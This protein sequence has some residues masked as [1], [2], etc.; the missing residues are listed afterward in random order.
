MDLYQQPSDPESATPTPVYED[1]EHDWRRPR[2]TAHPGSPSIRS[3]P[4][5]AV[6]ATTIV[7]SIVAAV[8]TIAAPYHRYRPPDRWL[9]DHRPPVLSDVAP[10]ATIGGRPPGTDAAID[11]RVGPATAPDPDGL[12]LA[13]LVSSGA[14]GR[15]VDKG[16]TVTITVF[17]DR[18]T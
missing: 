1:S 9:A 3:Q 2:L 14:H 16:R 11:P 13:A 7:S 6:A 18:K 17:T 8:T 12:Y 15:A 5:L 4:T 10:L